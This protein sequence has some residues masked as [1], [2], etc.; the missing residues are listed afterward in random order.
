MTAK[1]NTMKKT[2][3]LN[4]WLN[5][6][7][8]S[9]TV[10]F[11]FMCVVTNLLKAPTELVEEVG[12]KTFRMFTVLS[13]MLVGVASSMTIPFAVDGIIKKN[14]HL[15]RWIVAL[16]FT[17]VSC[18]TLTFL[19]ALTVLSAYAG[20][21]PMM[22]QGGNLYLHT[23]VPVMAIISFLFVNTSHTVKFKTSFIAVIPVFLYAMTYLISVIVVGEENG[24]WRDHYH[25]L[26]IM[27]WY[28]ALALIVSLA[29]G[30]A[31]LLRFIH[32]LMHRRDKLATEQY[33]QSSWEYDSPTIEEAIIRLAKEHKSHDEGGEVIVP[34]RIIKF[35]ETKYQS[36][37]PLNYLCGIYLEEYLK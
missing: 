36:N 23:I 15:H 24:G 4:S 11:V 20:F 5:L 16:T 21:G 34:R 13:N 10:V 12:L 22:L 35:F 6:I 17:G 19:I 8:S 1:S 25:F 14:Y 26:E 30:I 37:K 28:A 18:V 31:C 3:A 33:Y 9:L 32:N 27:P 7:F 2:H 29:F